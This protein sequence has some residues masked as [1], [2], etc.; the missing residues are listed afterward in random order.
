MTPDDVVVVMIQC[1]NFHKSLHDIYYI[2]TRILIVCVIR[3]Q[4]NFD[5]SQVSELLCFSVY[6]Q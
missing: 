6:T 5:V 3:R 1:F 2:T 4:I